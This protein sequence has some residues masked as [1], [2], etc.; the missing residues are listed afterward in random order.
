MGNESRTYYD[1]E[2]GSARF[3][4]AEEVRQ[5]STR[6]NLLDGECETGGLPLYSNGSDEIWADGKDTNSLIVAK[7]GGGKGRR[8][9]FPTLLSLIASDIGSRHV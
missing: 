7:T 8:V 9:L 1:Y 5:Y 4:E 3:A 2:Q 6:I